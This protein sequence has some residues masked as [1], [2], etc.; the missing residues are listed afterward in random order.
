MP[1]TVPPNVERPNIC[2][3]KSIIIVII[4]RVSPP[5]G[6]RMEIG[7][8][9]FGNQWTGRAMSPASLRRLRGEGKKCK[10]FTRKLW[11]EF[12]RIG[13]LRDSGDR[14]DHDASVS[15]HVAHE[16]GHFSGKKI[17]HE[18]FSTMQQL[19]IDII[20]IQRLQYSLYCNKLV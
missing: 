6:F 16:L 14:L 11:T 5:T 12:R 20:L 4:G 19:Y 8:D 10:K 1:T 17:N 7:G 9:A 3:K 18:L 13:F 15:V 2:Y